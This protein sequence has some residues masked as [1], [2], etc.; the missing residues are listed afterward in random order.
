MRQLMRHRI[1]RLQVDGAIVD[2]CGWG[3]RFGVDSL[4]WCDPAHSVLYFAAL[5]INGWDWPPDDSE[6]SQ[7]LLNF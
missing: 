7:K 5:R 6:K 1:S 4:A 2:S 3:E